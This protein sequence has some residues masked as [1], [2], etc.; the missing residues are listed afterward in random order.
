ML[1]LLRY[2]F[3]VS[4][5]GLPSLLN[6]CRHYLALIHNCPNLQAL[7]YSAICS[8][9]G[10]S[11]GDLISL[12]V[13]E[14]GFTV[15]KREKAIIYYNDYAD[16]E[17]T[18]F[19]LAHELGHYILAH[20][21]ESLAN[22]REANC[23]ARNLLCPIPVTDAFGL[24]NASECSD[25]FDVSIPAAIVALDKRTLDRN[26]VKP[27]LY[28]SIARFFDLAH[29]TKEEQ[30]KRCPARLLRAVSDFAPFTAN[31]RPVLE[32]DAPTG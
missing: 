17:T 5:F 3:V 30:I 10:M 24:D 7:S 32:L 12:S 14:Q 18:R 26:N 16:P 28:L 22:E 15:K 23:F 31:Y 2:T 8:R 29:L 4:L 25:V 21:E 1:L 9:F 20:T 19:T 11:H 6:S 13:S 27:D